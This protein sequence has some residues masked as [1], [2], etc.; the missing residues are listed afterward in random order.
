ME[1]KVIYKITPTNIAD[2]YCADQLANTLTWT[3][4]A[5]KQKEALAKISRTYGAPK[6][7][8]TDLAHYMT[9]VAIE[10]VC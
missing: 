10:C 5:R 1:F 3:V 8:D 2:G 7:F 9:D 4:K 6:E